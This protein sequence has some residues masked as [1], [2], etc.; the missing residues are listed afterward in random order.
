MDTI[1]FEAVCN[2]T[3]ILDIEIRIS[4][5]GVSMAVL[6]E[7]RSTP[8]DTTETLDPVKTSEPAQGQAVN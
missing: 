5:S 1:I 6:T 7:L 4:S 8:V 2:D 3:S